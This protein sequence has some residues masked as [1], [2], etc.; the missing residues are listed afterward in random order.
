MQSCGDLVDGDTLKLAD[1]DLG[2]VA[3]KAA[4]KQKKPNKLCPVDRI[5]R[6][7]FLE[8]H[9]RLAEQKFIKSKR[10]ENFVDAMRIYMEDYCAATFRG[11]DAHSWRKRVL[12]QE[13]CDLAI[14]R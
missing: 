11:I 2:K 9:I 3:V 5:I 1:V 4:D 7:N 13:D 6:Y 12:W 10:C 8:V 14:K